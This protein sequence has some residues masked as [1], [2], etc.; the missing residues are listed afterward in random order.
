MIPNIFHF[1]LFRPGAGIEKPFSLVHYLAI[2]SAFQLNQPEKI[3]LHTDCK[4]SG[5]CWERIS[6]R[7][8]V[9]PTDAPKE[10]MGKNIFHVAHKSDLVRLQ[11]L[12]EFGGT[13]LDLDTIC[14]KPFHS[15]YN[16]KFVMG[17]ELIPAYI[18]RNWRQVLKSGIRKVVT[19]SGDPYKT[20]NRKICSAVLLS[21]K[22]SH[23]V[24]LWLESYQTFRSKGRDDY[25]NEHS[26]VIPLKLLNENND[27]ATLLC[28]YSFHYPL[29]K[30]EHLKKM[31]EEVHEFPQAFAHHLWE[32]FSYNKYL[33]KLTVEKIMTE[34]TTYNLIA[35]R[36]LK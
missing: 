18:P 24:K 2:E 20:Q 14:V 17:E 35:R 7:V 15:L 12:R 30:E 5:E 27:M 9:I 3:Y 25:W 22:E 8:T 23:F 11:V 16:N 36:F 13:Y 10:F 6:H 1:V 4:P 21:E 31:F 28:P 19:S 26:G 32:S 34:D 29:Y 33:S